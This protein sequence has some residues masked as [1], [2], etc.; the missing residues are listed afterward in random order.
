MPAKTALC[1]GINDY[2]GT[3]ND[4]NGCVNDANDWAAEFKARGFTVTML[5]DDKATKANIIKEMKKILSGTKE[6]DSVVFQYSGHGSYVPDESGDETDGKDEC[7][8]PY[9]IA[10]ADG[11][12]NFIIDDELYEIYSSRHPKSRLV[13]I[14]D[15][16][17]SGTVSRAAPIL[18]TTQQP[19]KKRF[20]APQAFLS[21]DQMAKFGNA[22]SFQKSSPPGRYAGLL[23]AGC[24]DF[25]SSYDAYFQ[26]R[27]NGAFTFSAL[28]A[29]K[30]L[31]KK[32]S[33]TYKDWFKEISKLIPSQDYD[34]IPRLYGALSMKKWKVLI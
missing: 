16:C 20:L 30:K 4:L 13:I 18:S 15:S 23:M 12:N 31:G 11:R 27:P 10:T 22:V 17:H 6:N 2:P 19:R 8:C 34:Q 25:Q 21:K 32:S 14:S 3:Q 24:Q 33:V 1:I 28:K 29:L 26:N 9:D 5:L 7:I